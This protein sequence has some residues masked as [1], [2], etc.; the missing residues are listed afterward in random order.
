ME[1]EP[2]NTWNEAFAACRERGRPLNVRFTGAGD[3][4]WKIY[5]SGRSEPLNIPA[6]VVDA[7]GKEL[8]RR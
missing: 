2:F 4:A 6:R 1:A 8:E 3:S 5:P 7:I